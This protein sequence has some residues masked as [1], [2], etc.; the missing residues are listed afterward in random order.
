MAL[1]AV[2][3]LEKGPTS[4][5]RPVDDT[6]TFDVDVVDR[7][8]KTPKAR[9]LELALSEDN[10]L[11]FAGN[12]KTVEQVTMVGDTPVHVTFAGKRIRGS[13]AGLAAF[14]VT[15]REKDG[16]VLVFCLIGIEE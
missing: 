13:A 2:S 16:D 6:F 1:R 12:S 11:F 8:A 14:R 3:E 5:R 9:T 10:D 7:Q 15:L 4:T